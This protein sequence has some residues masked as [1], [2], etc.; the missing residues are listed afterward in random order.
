MRG[1]PATFDRD[2]H[3]RPDT[4]Q[5]ALARRKPAFRPDGTITT[6]NA[7]GLNSGAAASSA[8]W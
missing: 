3:T 6:G 8:A 4:T 1:K 7:P 2:E 5:E